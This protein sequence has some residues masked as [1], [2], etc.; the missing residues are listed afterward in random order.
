MSS[1]PANDF[2]MGSG[3]KSVS[4]KNA[5]VGHTVSGTIASEPTLSQQTDMK[6]KAPQFWD[7]PHNTQPKMQLVIT[8]LTDQREPG[9]TSDDGRRALYVKG[10]MRQ[11]IADAVRAAGADG[12]SVGGVLTV[13]Y[14]GDGP[15]QDKTLDPPKHYDAAYQAPANA[16]LM[17]EPPT[18]PQQAY[19]TP[20]QAPLAPLAPLQPQAA[21]S[22]AGQAFQAAQAAAPVAP[23]GVDPAL[24]AA[25]GNLS[26]ELAAQL[27]A[28]LGGPAAI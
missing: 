8:L 24:A 12:L 14:I 19:A 3:A 20:A 6:T 23:T 28:Q 13:R 18:A 21:P 11:A 15:Q 2:L 5:P 7:E 10:Q 22:V 9:D 1:N 27:A 26:P 4:W 16:A 17:G 25:L